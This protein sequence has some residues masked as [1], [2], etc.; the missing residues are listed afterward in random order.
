M[1]VVACP[2]VFSLEENFAGVAQ[3]VARIRTAVTLHKETDLAIDMSGIRRMSTT[4]ALVLAAALDL[5]SAG[6]QKLQPVAVDRWD[7][8]V[9]R[10]LVDMGFFDLLRTTPTSQRVLAEVEHEGAD[11][12]R[13]LKLRS[14]VKAE[15]IEF[16]RL[17]DDLGAVAGGSRPMPG[18]TLR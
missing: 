12:V 5:W 2:E 4:G 18:S 3:V 11:R 16:H 13:Y 8:V 7:S 10:Q 14:G 9:T 17:H 1:D 6:R 15:G